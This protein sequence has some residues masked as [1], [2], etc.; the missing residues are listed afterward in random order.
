MSFSGL[1]SITGLALLWGA[2]ACTLAGFVL[3]PWFLDGAVWGDDLVRFS[4][5]LALLYYGLAASL[6]LLARNWE[7]SPP[8]GRVRL[9][10]WF[11]LAAYCTYL[12]HLAMAMH[13]YHHWSHADAFQHTRDVAGIGEGIYISHLFTLFWGLDLAY[14]LISPDDYAAR[15]PWIG[16][17]LHA[18]MIFII[19]NGTVIYE[20]GFIRWAG[21]GLLC[22]LG[23]LWVWKQRSS[24]ARDRELAAYAD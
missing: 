21:I 22:V 17:I 20:T 13:Y 16:R 4:V 3:A 19:F 7:W 24:A 18:F 12:I 8:V 9:A 11:W 6:I 10:R 1:F 14:W 5:R 23:V 2:V 15:S